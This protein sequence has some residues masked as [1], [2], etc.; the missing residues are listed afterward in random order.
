MSERRTP[1]ELPMSPRLE[2]AM[3]ELGVTE[4]ERPIGWL[5]TLSLLLAITLVPALDLVIGLTRPQA[6]GTTG[7]S[8]RPGP[9][10]TFAREV[11]SIARALPDT[12][13]VA[14]NHQLQGTI[15]RFEDR[16]ADESIMRRTLLGPGQL[17]L[18]AVGGVGNEQAYTGRDGWLFY[19]PGVDHLTAAPFL[20]PA[21]QAARAR[22]GDAWTQP[23]A[24]D[25]VAAIVDFHEQLARRG[26]ILVVLPIPGKA[27]IHPERLTARLGDDAVPLRNR[28]TAELLRQLEQRGVQVFDPIATLVEMRLTQRDVYLSTDTHWRP[29]AMEQVATDLA[30]YLRTEVGL[31]ARPATPFTRREVETAHLGDVAVMLRLPPDQPLF[32][33]QSVTVHEIWT[34]TG[35]RWTPDPSADLLLLGD[36]FTNIFSTPDLGWGTHAGLAEQLAFTLARPV[37]RMSRNAGGAHSTRVDLQRAGAERLAGK[38]VVVW[39]FSERELSFG[40]WKHIDLGEAPA[41]R[42]PNDGDTAT[43]RPLT[44]TG[45]V[46]AM[47]RVPA[48][49][50]QPYRDA[51]TSIHLIEVGGDLDGELLVYA[52]G[53]RNDVPQPAT[54]LARGDRLQLTLVPW[55]DV[56][57]E[58]GPI[59]RLEPEDD[60]VLFLDPYW[61]SELMRDDSR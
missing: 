11:A 14:S 12:S 5:L 16:L 39:Q 61:A 60:D 24:P 29:E 15:D 50:S 53:L 8:E 55:A 43:G 57:T 33:E 28:S 46:G 38:R 45:R 13:L 22:G 18:T 20:D 36:S 41:T 47:T 21:W 31:P 58:M 10:R 37:D 3:R 6:M 1:H 52:W 34:P 23:P 54:A 44:V 49:G 2:Q 48:A 40:D 42:P 51:I 17:L 59:M 25:P 56:E 26:I 32:P 30:T 9:Y 7:A 19:R 35:E 4:I 27:T